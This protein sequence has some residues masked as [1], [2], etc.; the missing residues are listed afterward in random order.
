MKTV[1][2]RRREKRRKK[3][4]CFLVCFTFRVLDV[5]KNSSFFLF[6]CVFFCLLYEHQ[7]PTQRDKERCICETQVLLW[8]LNIEEKKNRV[9]PLL[10]LKAWFL[11]LSLCV[12]VRFVADEHTLLTTKLKRGLIVSFLEFGDFVTKELETRHFLPIPLSL[13]VSLSLLVFAFE[14]RGGRPKYRVTRKETRRAF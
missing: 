8:A 7:H 13:S 10:I 2:K 5:L 14:R 3:D 1:T 4:E 12:S 9:E 6:F 11:F